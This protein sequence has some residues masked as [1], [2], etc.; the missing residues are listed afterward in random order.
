MGVVGTVVAAV[1]D[2]SDDELQDTMGSSVREEISH[3]RSTDG[4]VLRGVI[5]FWRNFICARL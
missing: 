5:R 3:A 4:S 1:D 2:D